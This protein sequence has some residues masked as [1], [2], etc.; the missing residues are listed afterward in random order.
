MIATDDAAA[1]PRPPANAAVMVTTP[2]VSI[3]RSRTVASTI[4]PSVPSEP[5]NRAVRSYPVTPLT[6]RRPGARSRPSA[7]TT[8]SPSNGLA[9]DP[10]L[11]AEQAAGVRRDVAADGRDRPATAGRRDHRAERAEPAG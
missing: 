10:V 2:P 5:V 1:P 6:V 9:G 8:L 3:G 4:T 11:R 7:S